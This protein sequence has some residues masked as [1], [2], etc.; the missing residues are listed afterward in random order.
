MNFGDINNKK[1]F[2]VSAVASL[3]LLCNAAAAFA[4][5]AMLGE[6]LLPPEVVPLDPNSAGS[7]QAPTAT[8]PNA[9]A[10]SVTTD[11]Q[12]VPGLVNNGVPGGMQTAKDARQAAFNAL[13]G[14]GQAPQTPFAAGGVM[15]NQA[16][17]FDPNAPMAGSN[18]AP[19][20]STVTAAP[21]MIAS[22]QRLSGPT[23][24]QPKI[25]DTKRGGFSNGISAAGA[26]GTGL[27]LSG[28]L[29]RPTAPLM[30]LGIFG[31]TMTGFGV[32]NAFRF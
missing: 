32:R 28:A 22:T 11:G 8:A 9:G 15:Q 30:G 14:Q 2:G 29:M 17:G 31:A 24:N 27:L 6:D 19:F 3:L 12:V 1:A 20:G 23:K 18:S 26:F 5:D 25:R 21:P 4:Q 7:V 10:G 13:Y 16:P